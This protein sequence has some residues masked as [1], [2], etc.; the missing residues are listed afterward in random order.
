MNVVT[1]TIENIIDNGKRLI[2][3]LRYGDVDNINAYRVNHFGEESVIPQGYNAIYMQTSNS[4][5]PVCIGFINKIIIDDLNVGDKQIYSTDE[6]GEAVMAFVKLMNDGTININANDKAKADFNENGTI[7]FNA[8]NASKVDLKESGDIDVTA[9]NTVKFD[10]S[11]LEFLGNSDTAV[12][13]TNLK[14]G[15]D[16]LVTEVTT[17]ANV[18]NAHVHNV[19]AL[20]SPVP[21]PTLTPLT[22]AVPPTA[23]IDACE[24]SNIKTE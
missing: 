14:A 5:E 11:T 21:I 15:F 22:P 2:K 12:G 3:L 20:P 19:N 9:D 24:K 16:T 13:F 4:S 7:N 17:F 8:N 18:Y 1:K 23:T 10:A 6:A